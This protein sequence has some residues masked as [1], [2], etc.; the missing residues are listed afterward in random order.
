MFAPAFLIVAASVGY[1]MKDSELPPPGDYRHDFEISQEYDKFK[2]Q[3]ILRL[4]LGVVWKNSD[5]KMELDVFQRFKGIGRGTQ[6]GLARLFFSSV[7]HDGWRYLQHHPIVFLVDGDRMNFDPK[8]DGEVGDGSV[9]EYFWV[10]P[11]KNQLLTILKSK[12]VQV[13]VGLDEFA[14]TDTHLSALKEFF[15]YLATPSRRLSSPGMKI[16]LRETRKLESQGEDDDARTGYEE[17]IKQASGSYES[18][19]ASKGLTRLNDPARKESYK[20]TL[21]AK[22][23]AEDARQKEEDKKAALQK[24][25]QKLKLAQALEEKNPKGAISYYKEILKLSADLTP[26]PAAAEKARSRIKA[27]SKAK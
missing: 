9:L 17:V 11:S 15:S 22:T 21:E 6:D 20:K 19:E 27:L 12:E 8:Y 10:S 24:I 25:Q 13:R 3:T 14:L 2:D 1:Q 5:N 7:G 18:A 16:K 23:N 4:E 26:E